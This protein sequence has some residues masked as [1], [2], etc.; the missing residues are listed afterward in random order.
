MEQ[1]QYMNKKKVK[2]KSVVYS[3]VAMALTLLVASPLN[4]AQIVDVESKDSSAQTILGST[5]IPYREVT[6]AAQMPGRIISITGDVGTMLKKGDL[7]VKV[8]DDNLQAVLNIAVFT[9]IDY[10]SQSGIS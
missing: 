3:V 6:L 4:A 5:V 7:I 2:S 8:S 1:E 10:G 9:T